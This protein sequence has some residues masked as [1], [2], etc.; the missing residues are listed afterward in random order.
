[1]KKLSNA[2]IKLLERMYDGKRLYTSDGRSGWRAFIDFDDRGIRFA[3]ISELVKRG[4]IED[5]E[6]HKWRWR[7]SKYVITEAGRIAIEGGLK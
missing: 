6:D 7:G 4:L 2:Q 5:A 1:M 3:T